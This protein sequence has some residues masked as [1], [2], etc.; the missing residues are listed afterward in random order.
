MDQ[1]YSLMLL[2]ERIKNFCNFYTFAKFVQHLQV[3][4]FS[5]LLNSFNIYKFYLSVSMNIFPVNERE[6][7]F[8]KNLLF[9][10][11]L[12]FTYLNYSLFF[13]RDNLTQQL[14]YVSHENLFFCLSS[15]LSL[16][17][18]LLDSVFGKYSLFKFTVC[19][20]IKSALKQAI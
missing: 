10:I 18:F 16:S 2:K 4:S 14:H 20:M 13:S 8:Q 15:I 6:N 3:L 7:V 9:G 19:F 17:F 11:L 5:Q 1:F 12:R